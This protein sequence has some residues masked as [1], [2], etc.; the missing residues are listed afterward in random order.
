VSFKTQP[1]IPSVSGFGMTRRR[2]R[3][4][5]AR[6]PVSARVRRSTRG[7]AFTFRL[8]QDATVRIAIDRLLPGRKV[9]KRCLVP[10]RARRH[11]K[12]CTRTSRA[13]TLTR[14]YPKGG[15]KTVAFSGRIG[16]RALAPGSYR[17]TIT[18]TTSGQPTAS[19][20]RSVT[21]TILSG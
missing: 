7:T 9:G 8:S 12:R 11:S 3:R 18:A 10:T 19:K 6:T 5:S 15:K 1:L 21:F 16:R 13:G 20:S 2:F 17:A 14:R 4:S